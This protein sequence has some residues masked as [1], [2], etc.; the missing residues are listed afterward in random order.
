ME[1]SLDGG[2]WTDG[3]WKQHTEAD[4]DHYA[5]G[6]VLRSLATYS[7]KMRGSMYTNPANGTAESHYDLSKGGE[8][9]NCYMINAP[10]YYSL[11]LV[12]GNA[13]NNPNAYT[14]MSTPCRRY[15]RL[16]A[17]EFCGE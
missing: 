12:Y 5:T 11:P 1:Y 14:C 10:G 4:K 16:C 8:T 6:C 7:S 3:G 15:E 17:Y 9:A 2:E 13:R